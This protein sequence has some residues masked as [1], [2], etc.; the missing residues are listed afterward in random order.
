MASNI[1]AEYR[2]LQ[3]LQ[4]SLLCGQPE[5]AGIYCDQHIGWGARAFS[6]ESRQQR[7]LICCQQLDF[8]T[9]FLG[10]T[11]QQ[12]FKQ[13]LVTR[14]IDRD[15]IGQGVAGKCRQRQRQCTQ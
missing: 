8:R 1:C 10:V 6:I 3:R 12:R 4:L 2:R 7:A 9:G 15:R 14:G 13:L 5:I 11:V